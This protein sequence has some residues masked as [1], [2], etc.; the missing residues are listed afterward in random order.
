[1]TTPIL[2]D[3]SNHYRQKLIDAGFAAEDVD[4]VIT[5]KDDAATNPNHFKLLFS[6]V[7]HTTKLLRYVEQLRGRI[8]SDN[9]SPE[10]WIQCGYYL[11]RLD[12]G[13]ARNSLFAAVTS[14][15]QKEHARKPRS[16]NDVART[17]I[18]YIVSRMRGAKG[19]S[20]F[21]EFV[22]VEARIRDGD[23][24]IEI[25]DLYDDGEE[26]EFFN[27]LTDE[28]KSLRAD[29]IRKAISRLTK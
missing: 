23:A 15:K 8:V 20:G 17:A 6:E 26:Y 18:E 21:R 16:R 29:S 13:A 25:T 11:H 9:Q 19:L 10:E 27:N 22:G 5:G 7:A 28:R 1:M 4:A 12:M 2:D 24:D 3:L 14:E